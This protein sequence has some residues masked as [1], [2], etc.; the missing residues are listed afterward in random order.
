MPTYTNTSGSGRS[1]VNTHGDTVYIMAGG[2]LVT[3]QIL[4]DIEGWTKTSDE[5]YDTLTLVEATV[6]AG[7]SVSGLLECSAIICTASAAG[8]QVCPN[9]AAN[10]GGLTLIAGSPTRIE[11]TGT[12]ESIHVVGSGGTVFVQG[13]R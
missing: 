8:L 5:P 10:P 2:A 11:N 13:L 9:S 1:A 3:Y 7:A 4:D 6:A 12:I